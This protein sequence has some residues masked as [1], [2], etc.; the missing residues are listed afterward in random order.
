MA[1]FWGNWRARRKLGPCAQ[2]LAEKGMKAAPS[3]RLTRVNIVV[4]LCVAKCG[5]NNRVLPSGIVKVCRKQ[6]F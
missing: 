4:F 1:I 6:N 3:K 2:R 5:V